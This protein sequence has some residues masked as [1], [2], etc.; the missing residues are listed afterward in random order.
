MR[1]SALTLAAVLIGLL[2]AVAVHATTWIIDPE[3]LEDTSG[4]SRFEDIGVFFSIFFYEEFEN[5]ND[6]SE[7]MTHLQH[8][9]R[10]YDGVLQTWGAPSL[11]EIYPNGLPIN[12]D[13]SLALLVEGIDIMKRYGVNE[14]TKTQYKKRV[15]FVLKL[16]NENLIQI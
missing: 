12:F 2:G 15:K 1:S 7:T 10:G 9:I 6:I 4:V 11:N 8:F 14:Q 3:Y 16:L 5:T 13:V